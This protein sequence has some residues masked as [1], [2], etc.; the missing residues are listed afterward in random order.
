MTVLL[1]LLTVIILGGLFLWLVNAF[2][3]IDYRFK[4]LIYFLVVIV[5]VLFVLAA[6]GVHV[7]VLDKLLH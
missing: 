7:P 5:M 4:Q 1:T 3:P 6:F 2:L